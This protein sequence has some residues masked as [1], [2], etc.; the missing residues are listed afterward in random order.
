MID[1]GGGAKPI[2]KV[3]RGTTIRFLADEGREVGYGEEVNMFCTVMLV[4]IIMA[5]GS[6]SSMCKIVL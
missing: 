2:N 4:N 1:K 3:S 5:R 6:G